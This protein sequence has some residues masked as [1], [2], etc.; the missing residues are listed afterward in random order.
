MPSYFDNVAMQTSYQL[1]KENY[2]ANS[3]LRILLAN[4][5]T[6]SECY[7]IIEQLKKKVGCELYDRL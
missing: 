7:S 4:N 3:L 5:V 2:I 1:E 6:Q